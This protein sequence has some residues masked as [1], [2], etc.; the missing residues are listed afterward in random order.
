MDMQKMADEKT[1]KVAGMHCLSCE[2]LISDVLLDIGGVQVVSADFKKG[3]I[4]VRAEQSKL[5]QINAAIEKE[6]Y[7]VNRFD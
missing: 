6:G 3:E 4:R 1:I 5:A 7:K 2:V